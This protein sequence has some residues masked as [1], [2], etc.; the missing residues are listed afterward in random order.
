[1]EHTAHV[2]YIGRIEA[3]ETIDSRQSVTDIEHLPH[4]LCGAC[5]PSRQ[6]QG[7]ELIVPTEDAV[8]VR[9]LRCIEAAQI[10]RLDIIQII[11]HG[12]HVRDVGGIQLIQS[13]KGRQI[14]KC[15]ERACG[16]RICQD[17]TVSVAGNDQLR[18]VDIS[19]NAAILRRRSIPGL[20]FIAGRGVC[21]HQFYLSNSRLSCSTLIPCTLFRQYRHD[22]LRRNNDI[23]LR[24]LIIHRRHGPCHGVLI[25]RHSLCGTALAVLYRDTVIGVYIGR[26]EGD[27]LAVDRHNSL[28]AIIGSQWRT[29][30]GA[31][32][33][34]LDLHLIAAVIGGPVI[35]QHLIVAGHDLRPQRRHRRILDVTGRPFIL[36]VIIDDKGIAAKLYSCP[37]RMVKGNRRQLRTL[38]RKTIANHRQALRQCQLRK[39]LAV[40]EHCLG[41]CLGRI[42]GSRHLRHIP[43]GDINVLQR[44]TAAEHDAGIFQAR[45]VP[46][47]HVNS[48]QALAILEHIIGRLEVG[49]VPALNAF[50]C[51]QASAFHEHVA[52]IFQFGSVPPG[53]V[54][55]GKGMIFTAIVHKHTARVF[56]GSR[57]PRGILS[58]SV[59]SRT[60]IW[61]Q[62][63]T[64][65]RIA[66]IEHVAHVCY[67]A[68]IPRC[69]ADVRKLL[70]EVEHIRHRGGVPRIQQ[71]RVRDRL[72]CCQIAERTGRILVGEDQSIAVTGKDQTLLICAQER[73]NG[74]GHRRI[75]SIPGRLARN[76]HMII[77]EGN[78][79]QHILI[80]LRSGAGT[81]PRILRIQGRHQAPVIIAVMPLIAIHNGLHSGI[82][83]GIH[84]RRHI[85]RTGIPL[86]C[87][88]VIRQCQAI[89][90][91]SEREGLHIRQVTERQALDLLHG[92][93]N[94]H[95]TG[96]TGSV[97]SADA[98]GL[99]S[100]RE[101]D[102][103]NCA[104]IRESVV[105]DGGHTLHEGQAIHRALIVGPLR[106]RSGGEVLHGAFG[107]VKGKLELNTEL[108]G[109][110]PIR[111]IAHESLAVLC[112]NRGSSP[113]DLNAVVQVT[114]SI[115]ICA[116]ILLGE[117]AA[118]RR[119]DHLF[120][121]EF[122]ASCRLEGRRNGQCQVSCR[123]LRPG[124]QH[125]LRQVEANRLITRIDRIVHLGTANRERCVI[126][127]I[128]VSEDRQ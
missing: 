10:Q 4:V 78:V 80:Q 17:L 126:R 14:G 93:R 56:Q 72:E 15:I 40:G 31:A 48:L 37:G 64:R 69:D 97:K 101:A 108:P 103:L 111:Q 28:L 7:R 128:G 122:N 21:V 34:V 76:R 41:H 84:M 88:R 18:A 20:R 102:G 66:A 61:L 107:I 38:C 50:H 79:L 52:G 96:Q 118:L 44:L 35:S 55:S 23:R 124:R 9:H 119:H 45:C 90:G 110:V 104:E 65:E 123:I 12:L 114:G 59:L 95:R 60:G 117:P 42:L 81:E 62:I 94:S 98:Y 13:G 109:G 83:G 39:A 27:R 2:G 91:M 63:N 1:M 19:L 120:K 106:A 85:E 121:G 46:V 115:Q 24:S 77:R 99:H 8:E 113:A 16:I 73:R 22:P 70:V 3:A 75:R 11:E 47:R 51:C 43:L 36:T 100:R 29:R 6:V 5:I 127:S 32:L 86:A 87:R 25:Q 67:F 92:S 30:Q 112:L 58:G 26:G 105:A 89:C 82:D 54:H 74:T 57:V 68:H 33:D 53:G 71:I 125:L 116:A 49:H